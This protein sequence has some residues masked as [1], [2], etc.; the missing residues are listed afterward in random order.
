LLPGH[1]FPNLP[2]ASQLPGMTQADRFPSPSG[3]G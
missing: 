1:F 2:E 3:L